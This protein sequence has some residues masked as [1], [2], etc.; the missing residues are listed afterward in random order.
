MDQNTYFEK[1][2]NNNFSK[3]LFLCNFFRNIIFELFNKNT[4]KIVNEMT[5]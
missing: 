4:L 3:S 2:L 5:G 1:L